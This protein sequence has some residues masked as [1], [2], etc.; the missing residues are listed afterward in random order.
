MIRAAGSTSGIFTV[1]ESFVNLTEWQNVLETN[2]KPS[3]SL[4]MFG[5]NW[6]M[7]CTVVSNTT[8]NPHKKWIKALQ[9]VKVWAET[10]LNCCGIILRELN[11]KKM[12]QI[13]SDLMSFNDE[14]YIQILL[15]VLQ[16]FKG[17]SKTYIIL[18]FIYVLFLFLYWFIFP[19]VKDCNSCK[20]SYV[21]KSLYLVSSAVHSPKPKHMWCFYYK[22]KTWMI[23]RVI[24]LLILK[25][26]ILFY[27]KYLRTY[28]VFFEFWI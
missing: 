26:F 21:K 7:N 3:V 22:L 25:L 5:Q 14:E 13:L 6:D 9:L 19:P 4:L 10:L 28:L 11:W 23:L 1:P 18:W 2:L 20:I 24:E 12:P 16:V 15:Y 27:W 8:T 17:G